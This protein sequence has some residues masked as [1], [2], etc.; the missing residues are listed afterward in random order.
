MKMWIGV[1]CR[2]EGTGERMYEDMMGYDVYQ[3]D[4]WV[5]LIPCFPIHLSWMGKEPS[6]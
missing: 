4:M 6:M 3:T 5:C 2:R 1:F